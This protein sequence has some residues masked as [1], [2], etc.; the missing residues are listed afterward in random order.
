MS[1]DSHSPSSSSQTLPD[2]PLSIN[3]QSTS[4]PSLPPIVNGF[5]TGVNGSHHTSGEDGLDPITRLQQEL[6]RTREEREE[7]ATQYRSLLGKLQTMRNTLG[8]KLKQDAEEL[9][10]REQQIAQLNAQNGDFM[11]TVEALQAEVLAS[12]AEAERTARELDAMRQEVSGESFQREQALREVRAE[13]ERTRTARDDWEAEAMAQRVRAEEARLTLDATYRELTLAKEA[14]ERDVAARDVETERANNLQAV[15]ED[16][17]SAKDHELRQAVGERDA[18]LTDITQSLAEYKHR[19]LQAEL[20]LEENSTNNARVQTLEQEVKEKTLLIGK[21]RHEAVIINEHLMEALRRLRRGSANTNVDRRLVTNILLTFLNTPREDT[22]RFEIL[23]LLASILSW[24]DDE[25]AR[26]GLQRNGANSMSAAHSP[27]RPRPLELEKTDETESFSRL[28]VEFL[29]TE[30]ASGDPSTPPATPTR[31]LVG[32]PPPHVHKGLSA[33]HL[34]YGR[35]KSALW[36]QHKVGRHVP[37]CFPPLY[38]PILLFV[39]FCTF[40]LWSTFITTMESRTSLTCVHMTSFVPK[41]HGTVPSEH[42]RPLRAP[43][44]PNSESPLSTFVKLARS[45]H[46]YERT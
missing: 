41:C 45:S 35:S 36:T 8:N 11:S 28:W 10:R 17:Q 1:A 12:N 3:G 46:T 37:R 14:N 39:L 13:L 22:K 23:G 44:R 5:K 30:A 34:Q 29:L 18:Q 31:P 26:A 27:A 2:L 43:N 38:S 21:L 20:Q 24:S 7:Y 9:D 15:L 4:D 40:R 25:R 42:C 6:E 33:R 19:A 32:Y 16:F